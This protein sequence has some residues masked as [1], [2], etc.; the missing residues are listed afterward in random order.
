MAGPQPVKMTNGDATCM[1][2]PDQVDSMRKA[3]WKAEGDKE[4]SKPKATKSKA[5]PK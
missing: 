1:A 4:P 5:K 3:G 2:A